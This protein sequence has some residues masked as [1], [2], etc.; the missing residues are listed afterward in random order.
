[1]STYWLKNFVGIP[2]SD[3]EM[4]KV[5]RPS[6][7]FCV[8]VTFRS[9]QTGALLGSVLGPLSAMIFD[10]KN[11]NSK[12]LTERFVKGGT[13]GALIGAVMGPL[14]TYL[15]LR[16][17]NTVRL[18]DKC[19]RLR[20]DKQQLWQDRTCLISAALGYLTS[21]SLGLVVGLDLAVVMSNLMG[22]AW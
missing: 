8:H 22:K 15:A 16:D 6:T 1:M 5:P 7:E 10:T 4:L 9:I 3:F 2:Q 14:L 12:A 19:Y 20:F 21:G 17:M 11:T 18:Y 13:N